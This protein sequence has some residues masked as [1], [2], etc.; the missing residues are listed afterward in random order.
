MGPYYGTAFYLSRVEREP[1]FGP[2]DL[3]RDYPREPAET[4]ERRWPDLWSGAGTLAALAL[5]VLI[6]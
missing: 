2:R 1:R 3:E 6:F 5:V 4:A